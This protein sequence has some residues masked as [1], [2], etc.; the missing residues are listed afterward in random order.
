MS[1][2]DKDL[3][4]SNYKTRQ[5]L[6]RSWTSLYMDGTAVNFL[7]LIFPHEAGTWDPYYTPG[8]NVLGH[9]FL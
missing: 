2:S 4:V 9:D 5:L 6:G 7:K 1:T 3:P 8:V